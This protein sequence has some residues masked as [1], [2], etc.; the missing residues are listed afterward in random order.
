[1]AKVSSCA[2]YFDSDIF[3]ALLYDPRANNNPKKF[4]IAKL[5]TRTATGKKVRLLS[6]TLKT[7]SQDSEYCDHSFFLLLKNFGA[8]IP[9][10]PLHERSEVPFREWIVV[11]FVCYQTLRNVC[12]V[13][14]EW[15]DALGLHLEFDSCQKVLKVFQFPSF[16]RLMYWSEHR[17]FLSQ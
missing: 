4:Q 9:N 2:C 16:C 3:I 7:Y 8:L 5:Y 14:I 17:G 15:V 12:R 1:M 10:P 6:Q 11:P 13:R